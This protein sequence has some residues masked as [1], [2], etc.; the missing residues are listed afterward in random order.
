MF[1]LL[2]QSQE[3]VIEGRRKWERNKQQHKKKSF[4]YKIQWTRKKMYSDQQQ[5][6]GII[7][8]YVSQTEKRTFGIGRSRVR[9]SLELDEC[10]FQSSSV[11]EEVH[12][13]VGRGPNYMDEMKSMNFVVKLFTNQVNSQIQRNINWLKH[14]PQNHTQRQ[15]TTFI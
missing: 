5:S 12:E 3:F 14:L 7:D 4:I 15:T 11:M 8:R 10:G 9:H 2:G 1:E 6:D 13:V